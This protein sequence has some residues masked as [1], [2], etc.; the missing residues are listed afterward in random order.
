METNYRKIQFDPGCSIET[1][2]Q[3][4][5]LFKERGEL[6]YGEFNEQKLFFS[7]YYQF[8]KQS[9]LYNERLG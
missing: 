2:M 4:L 1:A 6:A 3:E 9:Y 7:W 8:R 5:A